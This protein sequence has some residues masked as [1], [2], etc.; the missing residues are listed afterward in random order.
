MYTY[1]VVGIIYNTEYVDEEDIGGWDLLWNEKYKGEILQFNNARDAFGTAMYALGID[2]NNATEADW[3]RAFEKLKEQKPLVQSYVMDEVF[4]KMESGEAHIA[5]YYAGDCLTMIENNESLA[6]YYPKNDK[7]EYVTNIFAD[8]MCIPKG[9]TNVALAEAY[10]NFML[11]EEAAVA[12]AEYIYYASPNQLVTGSEEYLDYL[13]EDFDVI[14]NPDME[15]NLAQMFD[16]YAYRNLPTD[17]LRL[18][19]NLWEELK[20]DS[21]SFGGEIYI[22][23]GVIVCGL[24]AFAVFKYIQKRKRRKLYW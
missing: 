14:Y 4:N 12:N 23:C 19:N 13:G 10:I 21:A 9:A 20:V 3:Q 18:L 8:A 2:V 24:V 15:G 11:G 7:G 5:A 1:G 22:I 17:K 16:K 6:F